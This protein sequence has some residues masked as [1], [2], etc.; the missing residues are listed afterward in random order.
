[1][2]NKNVRRTIWATDELWSAVVEAARLDERNVSAWIRQ[3]LYSAVGLK[4][5]IS[6]GEEKNNAPLNMPVTK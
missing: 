4:N 3:R 6:K 5:K 1:M 2:E